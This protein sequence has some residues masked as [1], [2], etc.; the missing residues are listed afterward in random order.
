MSSVELQ[1][2]PSGWLVWYGR[3]LEGVVMALM[4]ILFLEVMIGVVFRMAGHSLSWYDEVASIL[5]AWLTFYGSALASLRRSH[6]GCPEI[7]QQLSPGWRRLVEI[8]SQCLVI[9]F[10]A[11]LAWV[12]FAIMPIL[13]GDAMTSLPE[14]PMNL[15]QSTVPISATLILGTELYYLWLLVSEAELPVKAEA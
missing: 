2:P 11:T 9:V 4:V 10:F 14:V 6:I 7:V 8:F 3:L 15:M 12:G 5:L 1:S 13:A